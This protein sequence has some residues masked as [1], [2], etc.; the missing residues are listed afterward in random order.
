MKRT[1][2]L[3]VVLICGVISCNSQKKAGKSKTDTVSIT[4]KEWVVTVLG[5]RKLA[6]L[7]AE[8]LP[9][10]KLSNG[11]VSGYSSCNRMN[12]TYTIKKQTITF[13]AIAI[14]KMLCN[15]TKAIESKYLKSLSEIKTWKYE[16]DKLYFFDENKQEIIVFELKSAQ[17]P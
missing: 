4:D 15:E 12:G 1:T 7:S 10:L 8:R 17:Q 9:T 3:L 6:N 13:G 5:D 16:Q 14:T 2:Y 11:K